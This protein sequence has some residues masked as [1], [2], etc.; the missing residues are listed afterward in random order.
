M[1][2]PSQPTVVSGRKF[3]PWVLLLMSVLVIATIGAAIYFR[4]ILE[5]SVPAGEELPLTRQTST[6]AMVLVRGGSFRWGADNFEASLPP[7]YIDRTEVTAADFQRFHQATGRGP[8]P[9]EAD[10]RDG[11]PMS[12]VTFVEARDYCAW[13]GKRLPLRLEWE[14]A[15]RGKDGRPYPWGKDADTQRANVQGH[16]GAS[17]LMPADSNPASASPAGALN[18]V[19]NVMEWVDE[20]GP[21]SPAT[22]DK[23][24]KLVNPPP[25]PNQPWILAMGGGFQ[26][27]IA[28][29]SLNR[30]VAL[31]PTLRQRDVGFRCVLM[32]DLRRQG[33]SK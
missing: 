33:K 24:L 12:G 6:G 8:E 28:E 23:Y 32:P 7:L 15:A 13:A 20:S 9:A 25:P 21:P 27:P 5:G 29:A 17:G 31:P 30:P 10:I 16:S 11:L 3:M 19:G 14:K 1:T 22:V 26:T 2:D 4:R 18:M